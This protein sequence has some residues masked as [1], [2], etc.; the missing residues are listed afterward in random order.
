[1]HQATTAVPLP[2]NQAESDDVV[3]LRSGSV[4][5]AVPMRTM[6]ELLQ[7]EMIGHAKPDVTNELLT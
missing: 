2:R 3:V 5:H 7:A 4:K 1:M 6:Q